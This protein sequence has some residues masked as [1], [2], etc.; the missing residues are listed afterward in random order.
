MRRERPGMPRR[1]DGRPAPG[2]LYSQRTIPAGDHRV[3]AVPR[4]WLVTVCGS[5]L[6]L[7]QM[8]MSP[9]NTV[10]RWGEMLEHVP[11]V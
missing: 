3:A 9:T 7:V 2:C 4:Y 11:L 8:T 1:Q 10:S 6:L 5:G